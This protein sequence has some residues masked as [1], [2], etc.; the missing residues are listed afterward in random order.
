MLGEAHFAERYGISPQRRGYWV[1]RDTRRV[2]RTRG[3][4]HEDRGEGIETRAL[5]FAVNVAF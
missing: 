3:A 5:R 1:L 4:K 2:E